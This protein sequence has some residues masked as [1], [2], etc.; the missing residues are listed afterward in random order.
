[1]SNKVEFD[2]KAAEEFIA[3]IKEWSR[4]NPG[5]LEKLL[6]KLVEQEQTAEKKWL[7][8]MGF[9]SEEEYEEY[10]KSRRNQNDKK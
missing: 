3:P 10:I 6:D 5:K 9:S 7:N 1:M 8:S 4:K 2:E